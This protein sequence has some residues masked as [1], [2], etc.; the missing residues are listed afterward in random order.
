M[1]SAMYYGEHYLA[2][3]IALG[4]IALGVI[5]VLR[6]FGIIGSSLVAVNT[7]LVLTNEKWDA[8]IWLLAAISAATLSIGLHRSEHHLSHPL[9]TLAKRDDAVWMGEHFASWL[10][11]LAAIALGVIGVLVGFDVFD[12]ANAQQ[13][14]M[15]WLLASFGCSLLTV[16]LHGVR[17]QQMAADEDYI[18]AIVEERAGAMGTGGVPRTGT[19]YNR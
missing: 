17:H 7:R 19:E 5:G 2:W 8:L 12:N 14:G 16:T 1:E 10:V 11:A 3:I 9:E 18:V 6:G 15:I 13:D 4:A